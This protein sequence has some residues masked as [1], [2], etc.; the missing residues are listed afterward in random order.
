M[1]AAD[2][3]RGKFDLAIHPGVIE[4]APDFPIRVPRSPD[5]RGVAGS[6]RPEPAER[7]AGNREADRAGRV[8]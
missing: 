7:R 6:D 5:I 1:T 4:H 8:T 2:G 3:P